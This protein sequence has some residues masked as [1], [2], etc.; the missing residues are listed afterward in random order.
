MLR[1]LCGIVG[2]H[3]ARFRLRAKKLGRIAG[4]EILLV[5]TPFSPR[6]RLLV[7]KH[8]FYAYA[9][10]GEL[11]TVEFIKGYFSRGTRFIDI[12]A[13]VGTH[14][15]LTAKFGYE[16][17]AFDPETLCYILTVLNCKLNDVQV[18]ARK[19]AVR[20]HSSF[21]SISYIR[22]DDLE[23]IPDIFKIDVD[24]DELLVVESGKRVLAKVKMIVIELRPPTFYNVHKVL[25]SLGFKPIFVESLLQQ[26]TL[27]Q[28][29][30]KPNDF[31]VIYSH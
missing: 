12:G 19:I 28:F 25:K 16:V 20:D 11:L 13:G 7:P 23:V 17:T 24:G 9:L 1:K 3:H 8:G 31:N 29:Y 21:S 15:I 14:S 22:L 18:S 5:L 2:K 30:V 10:L 4:Q 27:L 6:L 26:A